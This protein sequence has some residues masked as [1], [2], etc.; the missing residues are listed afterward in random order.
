MKITPP[1]NQGYDVPNPF[2][3]LQNRF[4]PRRYKVVKSCEICLVAAPASVFARGIQIDF[5]LN[6][7]L[8][9][10]GVRTSESQPNNKVPTACH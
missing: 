6:S 10:L 7:K 5:L 1:C 2:G 8:R 3:G 9:R 4:R